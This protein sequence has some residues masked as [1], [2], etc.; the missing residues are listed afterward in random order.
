M[1]TKTINDI[2]VTV[3][4]GITPSKSNP[5]FWNTQ[6][7]PW[8]KT[9][10]LGRFRIYDTEE[11]ISQYALDS[12]SIKLWPVN[13]ISVAMYGEGKTRG[14]ASILSSQV[15]TNQACCNI[16][17]NPEIADYRFVYYWLKNNYQQ[18]RAL[19][20][21]VRKNLNA[22][23]IKNFP[24]IDIDVNN[25]RKIADILFAIDQTIECSQKLILEL[26]NIAKTLYE[27]WFVQFDFPNADGKPYRS[28]G[29]EMV[30]N[31]ILKREIPKGWQA[32]SLSDLGTIVAGGTPNT[33]EQ[34]NYLT[35]GV[36]WVTPNDLSKRRT[37]YIS[38]G[39][40]DISEKG[41]QDSSATLVPGGSVVMSTRAPIGL[42]SI[43]SQE[44]ST[45]QGC[46]AIVPNSQYS[47]E[48][49]A[50]TLKTNLPALA[51][52]GGG[53]TF[54]EVSKATLESFKIP[55]P[56][57]TIVDKYNSLAQ[58]IG[59][60]ILLCETEINELRKMRDWLLPLL[61][62]GQVVV[63]DG[64][65]AIRERDEESGCQERKRC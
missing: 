13:T 35:K 52:Q 20:S 31:E 61:M 18:L 59:N 26:E 46:K 38:H 25:Q 17:V 48:Y 30:Y 64:D 7:I 19:S 37:N 49:I 42:I 10:Q 55:I 22:D 4:S 14:N 2:A 63:C 51:N 21:G 57:T 40:R 27:Y 60:N 9:G 36:A 54:K 29:G 8:L 3:G 44:L 6:E 33:K 53:T 45:N 15:T 50:F 16:V 12:T 32:G 11:Y 28:S 5:D 58:N 23:D 41:L 1:P 24:F 47:S 62:N 43:A 56:S 65:G 39:E 34:A